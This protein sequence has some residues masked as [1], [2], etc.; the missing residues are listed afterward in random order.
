M[1]QTFLKTDYTV[2]QVLEG[3]E[4]NEAEGKGL[5]GL[6]GKLTIQ[7]EY[8]RNY[9]YSENKS[10]K[11]KAVI[12][13]LLNGYPLGLLYFNRLPDGRLE[14]LDGQQR[15]TSIGRYLKRKFAYVDADKKEW[16]FDA[17]SE[18]RRNRILDAQLLIYE[19]VGEEDDIK[20]WFKTINTNGEPLNDQEINNAI[21]SGP[22]VTLAKAEFSNSNNSNIQK[23]SHYMTGNVKRQEYLKVA[24]NWVSKGNIS[25]YMMEHRFDDNINE[26]KTYF[27]TVIDW[28]TD[29]FYSVE[30]EM[31]N[32]N[33]GQMYERFHSN[34]Y[35][36]KQLNED[37]RQL[38]SDFFV[39]DKRGIYEY[40]LDGK[41]NRSLLEVR[42]FEEPTKLAKYEEQTKQAKEKGVSNCPDCEKGHESTQTRIWKYNEM[43]A[44]HVTAWSNKGSTDIKNCQMLCIHH[45]RLKGNK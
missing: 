15:I 6:N 43:E 3:F 31:R 18:E 23:W 1:M 26:L 28:V 22:F 39:K 2:R 17:L 41:K 30:K 33:W 44:D 27:N 38:Y 7:P 25:H 20:A 36:K 21:F 14:V 9:I 5:F 37:V 13:S 35:D 11:E 10:E 29:M 32:I 40:L 45:N 42:L 19:C 24:L 8:Q 12:N 4:W 16:Y 34:P